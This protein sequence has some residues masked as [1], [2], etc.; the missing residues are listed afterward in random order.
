MGSARVSIR[1]E[2][3]NNP[4]EG[5]GT[6][7]QQLPTSTVD[8]VVRVFIPVALL[9]F[10]SGSMSVFLDA[11]RRIHSGSPGNRTDQDVY[12]PRATSKRI[13]LV[14]SKIHGQ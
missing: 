13:R 12:N 1:V 4:Y 5:T 7:A 9:L 8:S 10:F 3:K 2:N 14:P 11:I 6:N